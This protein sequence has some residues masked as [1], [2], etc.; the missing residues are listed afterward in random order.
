M[1]SHPYVNWLAPDKIIKDS[2]WEAVSKASKYA[3]GDLLD[4]GCGKKPY[5]EIFKNKVSS[6]T[7]LDIKGGDVKGSALNLPFENEHFETIFSSM[8]I[9]HVE[10][11]FLMMEEANRVLKK[12]GYLIITAPLFWC[13]HEE[14][15]DF[16]RFTK[17]GL[18]LLAEKS[19]LKIVYIEERGNW[20][21]T[22][23]QMI[24]LF[25]ESTANRTLLRYPKKV[26]Q[27]IVQYA[28]W[29]MSKIKRFCKNKQAPIGYIMVARKI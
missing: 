18:S 24:S 4:I 7:G 12:G 11:P 21:S 14:P 3:K 28:F 29:Q 27:M 23:G 19:G 8:V 6:Y 20:P 13:L 22:L 10:D 15:M 25:F 1:N 9:E 17:Y 26:I 2:L 16:F 5:Y